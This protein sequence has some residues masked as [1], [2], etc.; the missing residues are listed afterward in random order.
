MNLFPARFPLIEQGRFFSSREPDAL[1]ILNSYLEIPVVKIFKLTL[2]TLA[3]LLLVAPLSAFAA[4]KD[5]WTSVRSKNFHLVG[6]A[7]EK[8]IRKV[9]TRLEQFRDIMSRLLKAKLNSSV[10]IN[11]VVF[12]NREA[13]KP[14]A[15]P[16]TGGYFQPGP[17]VNYIALDAELQGEDPFDT[18]FHEYVHFIVKNN[19]Q[20]IPLWFNEGLAE[21]YST[22]KVEKDDTKITIGKPITRHVFNL[23]EEKMIPLQVLFTVDHKSP[24]YNERDKKGVFYSQSWA[25][26][27]YLLQGNDGKNFPQFKVFLD[28]LLA[29]TPADTAFQQ[30]FQMDFKTME[31]ALRDYI[32]RDKYPM[33]EVALNQKAET[34]AAAMQSAPLTEAEGQYY[35]GDLLLHAHQFDRAEKHLQKALALDS[36]LAI[37]HASLGVLNMYKGRFAEAKQ[38]LQKAVAGN[39]QNYLAHYYY[40]HV[41]MREAMQARGSNR[42]PLAPET[43]ELIRTELKKAIALKPDYAEAHHELAYMILIT[44]GQMDEAIALL[45]RA[46]TLSPGD[47]RFGFVLAQVYM[48]KQ[49]YKTS[50]RILEYIVRN[51]A[52]AELGADAKSML[53]HLTNTEAQMAAYNS[54]RESA[55]PAGESDRP[56]LTRRRTPS[57]TGDAT[58]QAPAEVDPHQHLRES[59][60]PPGDS[61]QQVRGLLVRVDCSD[62]GITFTVKVGERLLK[63]HSGTLDDVEF[64]SWTTEISGDMT[65]GA[66]NPANDVVVTYRAPKDARNGGDGDAVTLDFVPKGFVLKK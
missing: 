65:C 64:T 16:N 41:L 60:R 45:E 5:N 46:I 55:S 40:A 51:A 3:C 47:L 63:F 42:Q 43:S 17:D 32:G 7:S 36:N 48:R 19:F 25:L 20:N 44:G 28:K 6:N 35:L 34:D 33:I 49:D 59:M 12:K 9:A 53:D 10:P 57:G 62:K 56:A 14:F 58:P 23:R 26:V 50:R 61:E 66:R 21:F 2:A 24:Y 31:K 4:A 15:P 54:R 29:G 22:F 39:S 38:Y 27:H 8:D 11:V 30:A 1:L 52:D 37:A 18:I 13:Y